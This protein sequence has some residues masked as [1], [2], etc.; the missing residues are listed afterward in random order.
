MENAH[1]LINKM[2]IRHQFANLPN[3][4]KMIMSHGQNN[5]LRQGRTLSFII[6]EKFSLVKQNN[7]GYSCPTIILLYIPDPGLKQ[8]GQ[9]LQHLLVY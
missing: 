5:M 3:L 7:K 6:R 1:L 8:L 9:L 4:N 2:E